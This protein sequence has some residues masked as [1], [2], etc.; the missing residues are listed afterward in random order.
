MRGQDS[1]DTCESV[2]KN[3]FV[4]NI[5]LGRGVCAREH[6]SCLGIDLSATMGKSFVRQPS[7]S[8]PRA[9]THE[10]CRVVQSV[11]ETRLPRCS[12]SL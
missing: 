10:H 8:A 12:S 6:K 1:G 2:P 3:V 4:G 5:V 9:V 7:V 11:A